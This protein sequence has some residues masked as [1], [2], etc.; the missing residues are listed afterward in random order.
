MPVDE[1]EIKEIREALERQR[2]TEEAR[3]AELLNALRESRSDLDPKGKLRSYF[4]DADDPQEIRK[5]RRE[6]GSN[7]DDGE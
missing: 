1:S 5:R 6:R 7:D 2:E 3:H 4:A